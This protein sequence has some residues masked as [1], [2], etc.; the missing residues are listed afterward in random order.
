MSDHG[1]RQWIQASAAAWLLPLLA[2]GKPRQAD[3]ESPKNQPSREPEPPSG[4]RGL[5]LVSDEIDAYCEAHTIAESPTMRAIAEQTRAEIDMWIMMIGA[6]EGALLRLLVQLRGAKRVLEIGTFTGYSAIAMA[7]GLP[8]DGELITCD[9][10]E[11]WTNLAKQHWASSPHGSKI[12][13][14]L[15]PALET[16]PTIDGPFELAFID[17]DKAAYPDYYDAILP[18]L[19]PGGLLVADNVL[20]GGKVATGEAEGMAAFN[21]K[22]RADARVET[23]MLP[24]RDGVTIAR[25]IG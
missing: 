21:R 17:A 7:E 8:A 1:R 25:K 6:V 4:G 15:G 22:V 5:H 20:A 14:R 3:A 18:K 16:L 10:S 13:L 19:A 23:L 12:K 24:I 2:C 9:V 11:E